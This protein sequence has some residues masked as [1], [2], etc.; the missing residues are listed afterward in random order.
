MLGSGAV[1]GVA[2][3]ERGGVGSWCCSTDFEETFSTDDRPAVVVSIYETFVQNRKCLPSSVALQ[4]MTVDCPIEAGK[5]RRLN[6]L[7][8]VKPANSAHD[9]SIGSEK[10]VPHPMV[11]IA[12]IAKTWECQFYRGVNCGSADELTPNHAKLPEIAKRL[13]GVSSNCVA[14]SFQKFLQ[15]REL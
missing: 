10:A 11:L 8:A 3:R 7:V 9:S 4:A 2:S 1:S 6:C 5:S 14:S 12:D 13:F 15:K